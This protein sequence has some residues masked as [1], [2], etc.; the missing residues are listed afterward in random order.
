MAAI[1]LHIVKHLLEGLLLVVAR[2]PGILNGGGLWQ[3]GVLRS[4]ADH[5]LHL[6]VHFLGLEVGDV[7]ACELRVSLA[8]FGVS[9]GLQVT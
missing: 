1:S 8:Q 7:G 2:L 5:R 4:T 6:K 9:A 3:H